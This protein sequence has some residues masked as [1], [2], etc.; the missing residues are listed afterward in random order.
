MLIVSTNVFRLSETK[1]YVDNLDDLV[2][3][4]IQSD[5]TFS[6]LG[7]VKSSRITSGLQYLLDLSGQEN[8]KPSDTLDGLNYTNDR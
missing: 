3:R 2:L 1:M 8:E 4:A 5:I 6:F 7:W